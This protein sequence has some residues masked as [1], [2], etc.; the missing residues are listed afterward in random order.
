[1]DICTCIEVKKK[2]KKTILQE[3]TWEIMTNNEIS[4][5]WVN[6]R[7]FLYWT[8]ANLSR[9]E[10]LFKLISEALCSFPQHLLPRK[11]DRPAMK[12]AKIQSSNQHIIQRSSTISFFIKSKFIYCV[13]SLVCHWSKC[14]VWGPDEGWYFIVSQWSQG[15]KHIFIVVH[16]CG[17]HQNG[18]SGYRETLGL[19]V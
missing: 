3:S 2:H 18:V 9:P 12:K 17:S 1:M 11:G 6:Q 15:K 4:V 14:Q 16:V 8:N 10:W 7:Y 13:N 5:A 19:I